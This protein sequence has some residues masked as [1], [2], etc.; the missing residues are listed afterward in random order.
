MKNLLLIIITLTSFLG[1]TQKEKYYSPVSFDSSLYYSKQQLFNHSSQQINSKLNIILIVADDLGKYDL[2]IYGNPYIKTTNI[3]QLANDGVLYN[4]TYA[5]A[6]VCSPSRA[7]FITG[8]YQQRFGFHVQPHQRY[9]K[10]KFELWAFQHLINTNYLKPEDYAKYPSKDNLK[11]AGLPN[12]EIAIS[13]LLKLNGYRTAWIGKWHLGYYDPLLPKNFG[14]D[15]RYGCYEAYTLFANPKDKS[16]VNAPIKEFTDKVIW[17]GARK[18]ACAIRENEVE[19]DEKEYITYAF[20]KRAKQFIGTQS[21]QPF[22]VYLPINAPHTPYQAPKDIY[23]SLSHI[24]EHNKRVYYSMIVALDNAIG[25]LI[26]YLKE[27]N[28]YDN[29]L[30]IFTS[31]NGAALY[32]ETVDN[33]PLNGGKFTLFEG[34]LNVPLILHN[35]SLY[36]DKQVIDA[37]V[38]LLDLFPTIADA[39]GV[40]LPNDR[41]YDGISLLNYKT[42][43]EITSKRNTL[44]WY[45]DYNSAIRVGNEK[46][47]VNSLDNTIGYFNLVIDPWEINSEPDNSNVVILQQKLQQWISKMPPMFWPRIMNYEIKINGKLYRWAV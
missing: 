42:E 24:K 30:I 38:S 40:S 15:Y 28:Q 2:S 4:H 8:R 34:G 23:D 22:F 20:F 31:D 3:D 13:E 26:K 35:K 18:G 12:S 36:P 43:D 7:G 41:E 46:I 45:S 33:R 25:D 47:I 5:T 11:K 44:Y 21:D 39:A 37:P 32:T 16:V 17:K 19:I 10:N 9:P 14:F 29:T 1:Y 27:T 6:A